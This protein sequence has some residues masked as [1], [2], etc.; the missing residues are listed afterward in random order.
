ML[1]TASSSDAATVTGTSACR[2]PKWLKRRS[3]SMDST[4]MPHSP[5]TATA[6]GASRRCRSGSPNG[7][8][9]RWAAR[10]TAQATMAT[11]QRRTDCSR[12]HPL[13]SSSGTAIGS[14]NSQTIHPG[15][16]APTA[17]L[18]ISP[19]ETAPADPSRPSARN[20]QSGPDASRS[21]TVGK[22]RN[23]AVGTASAVATTRRG[24]PSGRPARRLPAT[25]P[26]ASS[27][28]S[29]AAAGT[30]SA[31]APAAAPSDANSAARLRNPWGS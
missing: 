16:L 11:I 8:A 31:A 29:P 20:L 1:P 4:A 22:A 15:S 25:R 5:A 27:P 18:R 6:A 14:A 9:P 23:A 17:K 2:Q 7:S 30:I 12:R 24:T 13:P 10:A 28:T 19:N 3:C 21:T 26:A